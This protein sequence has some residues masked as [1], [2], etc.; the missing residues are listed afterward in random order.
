MKTKTILAAL[1]LLLAGVL[2]TRAQKMRVNLAN[3]ETF[4]YRVSQVESVTFDDGTASPEYVDLGLPSGTLWATFNVG[5][6][7]PE[8]YG[9]Y[10]AWSETEP[11]ENYTE[12][13]YT[14]SIGDATQLPEA[15]D[16]ATANW[17]SKWRMPSYDQCEELC[18]NTTAEWTTLNGAPVLKVTSNIN[19]NSIIL[20]IVGSKYGNAV[21]YSDTNV[22]Y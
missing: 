6:T 15:N 3:G 20:P 2:T 17:G 16:E 1:L 13:T 12:S 5:A 8:E 19:G 11:K 4:A 14:F 21:Y 9:D 18:K 10:F 22:E 7:C